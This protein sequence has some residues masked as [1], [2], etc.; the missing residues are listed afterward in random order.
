[1]AV[2]AITDHLARVLIALHGDHAIAIAEKALEYARSGGFEEVI[3]RWV[4]VIEAIKAA[5]AGNHLG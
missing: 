1:M 4:S 3:A 5:Q 2:D